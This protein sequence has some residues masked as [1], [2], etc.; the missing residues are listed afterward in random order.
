MADEPKLSGIDLSKVSEEE[1]RSIENAVLRQVI[2]NRL[3]SGTMAAG[4]DSHG[5]VHSKNTMMA[6][7]IGEVSRPESLSGGSKR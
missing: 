4:H 6:D 1:L 5:S 7:I 2:A 3:S